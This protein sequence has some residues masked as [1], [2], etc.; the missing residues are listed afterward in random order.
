MCDWIRRFLLCFLFLILCL[1]EQ[2]CRGFAHHLTAPSE[3]VSKS[4]YLN[5]KIK[6][7]MCGEGARWRL[8]KRDS[9]RRWLLEV[10]VHRTAST[11]ACEVASCISLGRCCNTRSSRVLLECSAATLQ[12]RTPVQ[13]EF[14]SSLVCSLPTMSQGAL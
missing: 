3:R 7:N 11:A 9:V 1:R 8:K 2:P 10:S 14:Y 4:C 6:E 13:S 5:T 12:Q